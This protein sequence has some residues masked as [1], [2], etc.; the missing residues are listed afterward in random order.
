MHQQSHTCVDKQKSVWLVTGFLED[1]H[2]VV[3]A[4]TQSLSTVHRNGI[5]SIKIVTEDYDDVSSVQKRGVP[6][7]APASWKLP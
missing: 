3:A 2:R 6:K 4:P 7:S 1:G 5:I